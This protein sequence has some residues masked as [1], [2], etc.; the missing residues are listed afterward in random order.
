MAGTWLIFFYCKWRNN[1]LDGGATCKPPSP[2][3][4]FF[5][6]VMEIRLI[7][8]FL[9]PS[10]VLLTGMEGVYGPWILGV[11]YLA[12]TMIHGKRQSQALHTA[13]L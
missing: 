8:T 13:K 1:L 11:I 3:E 7:N 12:N 4:V 5:Y 9:W 2:S 6:L 10:P